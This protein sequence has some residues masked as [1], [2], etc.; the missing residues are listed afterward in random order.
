MQGGARA[1]V[2]LTLLE[3]SRLL[4]L[5]VRGTVM[6]IVSQRSRLLRVRNA[7]THAEVL[8]R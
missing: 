4:R 2:V 5:K 6:S 1:L 8:V 3:V 7:H